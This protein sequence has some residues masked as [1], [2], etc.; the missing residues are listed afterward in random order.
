MLP[1]RQSHEIFIKDLEDELFADLSALVLT[2][3]GHVLLFNDP[4][5][6]IIESVTVPDMVLESFEGHSFEQVDEVEAV[7]FLWV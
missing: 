1:Y 6:Y 4:V 7:R 2:T 5:D 3:I